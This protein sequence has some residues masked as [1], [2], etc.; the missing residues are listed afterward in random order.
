MYKMTHGKYKK[1]WEILGTIIKNVPLSF[2]R[3]DE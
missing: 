3:K 1:M 2:A